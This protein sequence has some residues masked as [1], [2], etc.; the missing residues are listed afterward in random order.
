MRKEVMAVEDAKKAKQILAYQYV[1]FFLFFTFSM[2]MMATRVRNFPDAG[3]GFLV[4]L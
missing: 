2:R 1:M 4:A 3:V